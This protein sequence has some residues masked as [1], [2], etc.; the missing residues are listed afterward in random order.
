MRR[1]IRPWFGKRRFFPGALAILAVVALGGFAA[2]A[3][4]A[5]KPEAAAQKTVATETA[6]KSPDAKPV[7]ASAPGKLGTAALSG[8]PAPALD[9]EKKK[10]VSTA[11]QFEFQQAKIS[12]E[13]TELEERMFRLSESLKAIE[14]EN[15]SRLMIGLK[16]A[17]EELIVHQM[18][19][20]QDELRKASLAESVI[21]QKELLTKL[22]RL[23]QLLLSAD[24]DFH[25]KMERLRQIR[26]ALRKLDTAIREEERERKQSAE[27]V[28]NEERLKRLDKR[29]ATLEELIKRESAHVERGEELAQA[30]TENPAEAKSTDNPGESTP[31]KDSPGKDSPGKDSPAKTAS[32]K[33]VAGKDAVK[34]LADEQEATRAKTTELAAAD[35]KKA[36]AEDPLTEAGKEM[37]AAVD[38]LKKE[39][40]KSAQPAMKESLEA[41]KK[42][43]ADG[44]KEQQQ[45]KKDVDAQKFAALAKDQAGNRQLNENIAE[46]VRG[47]GDSGKSAMSDLN[48]SGNSMASAERQLG[49]QQAG[50]AGQDQESALAALKAAREKLAEEAERLQAQLRGEVKKRLLEGL[51]LMLEQQVMVREAT[52]T[53]APRVAK[54]SRQAQG[55]VVGLAKSEGKIIALADELINMVEETE[56]GYAL[57]AALRLVRDEMA[58]VQSS[59]AKGDA[60]EPVVNAEKQVEADLKALFEALKQMPAAAPPKS[61]K[62]KGGSE[63]QERELNRM[64]AEL[65]LLRLLQMRVNQETVGTDQKRQQAAGISAALRRQIEDIGGRQEDVR[66]VTEKLRAERGNELQ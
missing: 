26:E 66:D 40:P 11:E 34:K 3:D 30:D 50:A 39:K 17:R 56:F 42:A 6:E 23:E 37:S 31:G 44:R 21:E 1:A 61:G 12:A 51:T 62:G 16:Y 19:E 55:S 4:E 33:P 63:E 22:E 43:L 57:P 25:M 18:K 7:P 58:G 54:G 20:I 27:T 15:S 47:L 28:R 24:L 32:G 65:K 2:G 53:L 5:Q 29:L 35:E 10:N 49:G 14:P 45:L 60:T 38:Q 9:Q 13:M 41:L 8:P 64:V 36:P 59:L 46:M 48:N 52:A